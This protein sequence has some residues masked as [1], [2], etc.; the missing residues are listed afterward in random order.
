MFADVRAGDEQFFAQNKFFL[1]FNQI[2]IELDNP[3]SKGE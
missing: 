2:T 3:Q 1:F